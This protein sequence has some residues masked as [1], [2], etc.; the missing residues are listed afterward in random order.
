MRVYLRASSAR[1]G[2][3]HEN[4]KTLISIAERFKFFTLTILVGL[5]A[6]IPECI[7]AC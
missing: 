5:D 7:L 1:T 4:A 3:S 2:A 6:L